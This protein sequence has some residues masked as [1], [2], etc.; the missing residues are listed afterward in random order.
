MQGHQKDI[1]HIHT[2]AHAHATVKWGRQQV[3]GEKKRE[4]DEGL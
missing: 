1:S 3:K 2:H 4:K